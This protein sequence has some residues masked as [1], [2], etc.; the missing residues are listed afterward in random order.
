VRAGGAGAYALT[1]EA[2][3]ASGLASGSA[4]GSLTVVVTNRPPQVEAGPD[5]TADEGE[6]VQFAG[7]FSNPN[8]EDSHTIV[9]D[10]GYGAMAEGVLTPTHVYADD[11]VY[12]VTLTV[13]DDDGGVGRALL[14][15]VVQ[16]GAGGCELYPI[17]LHVDTLAGAQVGQEIRDILNGEG[18]GNFGWLSWTGNPNEP[19][20]VRSLTPPGDS[21]TYVNPYAPGDHD[22][23][24]GD[25]VYGKPGVSNS[26]PVRAALDNLKAYTIT[27]PVWDR[28]VGT[29]CTL[30]YHVVGF[31]R[32]RITGY[33]LSGQ[34]RISAV[35]L[36][37]AICG[38]G[39][40]AVAPVD[41][42]YL[43]DVSG[44]MGERYVG[45]GTK[46]EAAREAIRALNGWVAAQGNG[47][48]VALMTFHGA[49][50]GQGRPPRYPAEVR[51]VS[52]L[53]GDTATL[54]AALRQLRADGSTPTAAALVELGE[55]LA[56]VRE[57]DRTTVVV[58]LSDGVPTV[59]LEGHGFYDRDVQAVSLYGRRGEWRTPEAVRRACTG[60]EGSGGRRRRCGEPERAVLPAVRRVGGGAVG[61]HDGGGGGVAGDAAGGDG[62]RGGGA[63]GVGRDIQRRRVAVRGGAGGRG[64]L[65]GAGHVGVGGGAATGAGREPLQRPVR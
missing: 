46:L 30:K 1:V 10:L 56:G 21:H 22:L 65:C 57:E 42:V 34:D 51:L 17:A 25:W 7:S 28:A 43:L 9:W 50:T 24:A 16:E 14:T 49:G 4:T 40:G 13:T 29:G 37:Y 3:S 61:G 59:D 5:R 60:V 33:H 45:A 27:V 48:R 35:F 31:A 8:P 55:W 38:A 19:T 36:G 54:E 62:T 6:A 64:V 32:I 23:S 39:C 52:G 63:A 11:G 44:S 20:L 58:L 2:T 15:V 12:T 18:A 53:T 47:S 26:G 41:L